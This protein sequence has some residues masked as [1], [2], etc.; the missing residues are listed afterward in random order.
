VRL[1][2]RNAAA[3]YDRAHMRAAGRLL[4]EREGAH[5]LYYSAEDVLETMLAAGLEP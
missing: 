1:A 5:R 3:V 4:L 2:S